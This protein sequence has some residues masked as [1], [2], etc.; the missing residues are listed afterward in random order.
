MGSLEADPDIREGGNVESASGPTCRAGAPPDP[1]DLSEATRTDRGPRGLRAVRTLALVSIVLLF[2]QFLLG[3]WANLFASFPGPLPLL[4]P[5][6]Q[7]F[8]QGPALLALHVVIGVLLG[9]V[10]IAGLVSSIYTRDRR[11]ILLE[12]GALASIVFAGESG[13][14]F[15]LSDYQDD[16]YSFS[17]A[18]GFI[19]V[20]LLYS[21]TDLA[22]AQKYRR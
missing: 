22:K 2:L 9:I 15:V 4:N 17:M 10:S 14:E 19:L 11:L 8:T 5:I 3:M 20:F 12:V 18:A 1:G 21:W 13:I 6:D 16:F 7:I